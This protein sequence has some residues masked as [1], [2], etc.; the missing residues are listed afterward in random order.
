M[1]ITLK[2][3]CVALLFT[4]TATSAWADPPMPS[5]DHWRNTNYGGHYV[6]YDVASRTYVETINCRVSFRFTLVSNQRN[7]LTLFDASRG[8]T[9][10][11]DYQGMWLK[12]QGASDFS[13]YQ[14]GTFDTRKQFQHF[15][16]NGAYTGAITKGHGCSWVEWFPGYSAPSY[17][18]VERGT[19]P[20]AVE[21]FDGSRDLWVRLSGSSMALKFG[22]AAYAFF[23]N[24]H[25]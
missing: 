18:F 15:D 8:M 14:A 20:D 2:K 1:Y 9:V 6:L 19:A 16:A 4:L 11:L 10:R 3:L 25:W 23:K 5:H 17:Y 22:N 24:G 13:F 21:L 7:T 12:A